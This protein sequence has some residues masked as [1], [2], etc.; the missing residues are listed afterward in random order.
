MALKRLR[1]YATRT[2]II[3][4]L[5][6]VGT[7]FTSVLDAHLVYEIGRSILQPLALLITLVLK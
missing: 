1:T 7:A 6:I 2:G 4:L 5:V 3:L